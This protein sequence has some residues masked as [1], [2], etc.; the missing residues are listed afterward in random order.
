MIEIKLTTEDIVNLQ[1]CIQRV[2]KAPETNLPQ[3]RYL[4]ALND[5]LQEAAVQGN[6]AKEP[7]D[8][9]RV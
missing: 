9:G 3:M 2:I 5:R 8:D 6:G 1:Y 4:L 7:E